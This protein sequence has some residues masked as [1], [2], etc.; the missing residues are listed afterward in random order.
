MTI[1][2]PTTLVGLLN[3]M[4]GGSMLVIPV[5]GMEAGYLSWTINC[6]LICIVTGYTAYLLVTHLGKAK[7]IKYLILAHFKQDHTY[8][9]LYNIVIWFSF[10][11][12]MLIYFNLFCTQI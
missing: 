10:L 5:L 12:A 3:A 9:S 11:S 6:I 4:I 1:G 8:T 2:T 7:N